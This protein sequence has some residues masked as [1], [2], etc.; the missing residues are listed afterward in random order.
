MGLLSTCILQ[1]A[2]LAQ[3]P[4][5][6]NPIY[7]LPWTGGSITEFKST[8]FVTHITYGTFFTERAVL[9]CWYTYVLVGLA[10][11][12]ISFSQVSEDIKWWSC[13]WCV[14][15]GCYTLIKISSFDAFCLWKEPLCIVRMLMLCETMWSDQ[16]TYIIH[17]AKFPL[18]NVIFWLGSTLTHVYG[19][20][21]K[22]ID[23]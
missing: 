5:C 18:K 7:S 6:T 2:S 10:A 21:W 1:G 11:V 20:H 16:T 4:C 14:R 19:N 23:Q 15:W 22:Q 17:T 12:K 13:L 9:L 3:G 8:Y